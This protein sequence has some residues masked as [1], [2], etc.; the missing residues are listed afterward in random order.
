MLKID[1][2]IIV[3]GK[4]DKMKVSSIVEG[5]IIETKGFGIF[6][7]TQLKEYLK[8]EACKNGI[9]V[10]TDSD[11]AGF[12]IRSYIKS[13]CG[14]R[15]KIY[16]VYLP[17]VEGKERR[18]KKPS[19]QGLLGVEGM[20][21]ELIEKNL[22]RFTKE[23]TDE[24]RITSRELFKFKLTGS[25]DSAQRRKTLLIKM[26]L[27]TALNT[28][29]LLKVLNTSMTYDEAIKLMQEEKE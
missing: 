21:R 27:P 25:A 16:N 4:Y 8:R 10:L 26:G 15:A 1:L 9:I 2:P 22:Q 3:E 14:E 18:K 17:E 29:S 5:N 6:K 12:K 20:E 24:R 11:K 23:S 7:S 19:S 13:F 28:N